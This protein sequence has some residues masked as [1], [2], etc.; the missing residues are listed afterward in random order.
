MFELTVASRQR[1]TFKN[2]CLY[3]VTPLGSPDTGRKKVEAKW[4]AGTQFYIPP[5]LSLSLNLK[6]NERQEKKK[7]IYVHGLF[8]DDIFDTLKVYIF[9]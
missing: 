4:L 5:S 2:R 9:V 8:I 6:K 1:M 7:D 3:S